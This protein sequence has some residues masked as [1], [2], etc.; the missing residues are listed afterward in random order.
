M[1]TTLPPPRQRAARHAPAV[2]G[3]ALLSRA[4]AALHLLSGVQRVSLVSAVAL[5]AAGWLATKPPGPAQLRVEAVVDGDTVVVTGGRAVRLIG[6]DTPETH[7]PSR[8]LQC[9]GQAAT[10]RTR[11]LLPKGTPVR[12]VFDA[13]HADRFGRALGYVYRLSDGLFVNAALVQG[14]F[15]RA[16]PIP[17]NLA[18]ATELAAGEREARSV[19]RGLW[20]EC[21]SFGTPAAAA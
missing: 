13:E 5:L 3:P 4:V 10:S 20:G 15:A 17:P 11:A 6:V 2:D 16:L 1:L 21:G 12:V 7:H 9:F 14:G 8:P 18:H 19:G